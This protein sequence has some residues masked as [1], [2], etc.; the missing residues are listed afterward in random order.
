MRIPVEQAVD[1]VQPGIPQQLL[2]LKLSFL[3]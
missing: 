2:D 3:E 1:V